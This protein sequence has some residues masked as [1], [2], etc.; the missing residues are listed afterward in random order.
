MRHDLFRFS[1]NFIPYAAIL[2]TRGD[3]GTHTGIIYRNDRD[4]LHVIEF[5]LGG[6][7]N[8]RSWSGRRFHLI[9]NADDDALS[10]LADYC[11]AMTTRYQGKP[12]EHL[13][14]VGRD[15]NAYV[16]PDTKELHLGSALG[17][18][19]ASFV[20]IVLKSAGID[21]VTS[22]A[23]WPYRPGPDDTRHNELITILR[24]RGRPAIHIELVM[25]ECPCP[26]VAPEEVAGAC[27]YPNLPDEPAS[28]A[29][30]ERAASWII[31]L[32]DYQ[33]AR[34]FRDDS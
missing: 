13:F 20:L 10:N 9:P 15:P 7:I 6:E 1:G 28:Q 22:G 26:R 18:S 19:C 14:G 12:A 27:M 16:H 24:D 2:I 23:D 30:C 8:T 5:C 25:A 21:L 11:Q 33:D 31:G 17:A 29:F 32:L 34:G 4:E 3:L